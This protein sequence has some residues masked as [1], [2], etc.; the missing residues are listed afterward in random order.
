MMF[1]GLDNESVVLIMKV[2]FV[3]FDDGLNFG[4]GDRVLCRFCQVS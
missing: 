4:I 3:F 2:D 1:S